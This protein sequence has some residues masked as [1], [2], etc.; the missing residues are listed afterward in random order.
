MIFKSAELRWF[1]REDSIPKSVFH[2]ALPHVVTQEEKMRTDLYLKTESNNTGIKIRQ[3]KH[4]LKL[5][6]EADLLYKDFSLQSWIKWSYKDTQSIIDMIRFPQLDD[7]IAIEK[8]RWI[9]KI[10]VTDQN[11]IIPIQDERVKRGCTLEYTEIKIKNQKKMFSFGL[12]AFSEDKNEMEILKFII[13]SLENNLLSLK[14][15][16]TSSYPGFLNELNIEKG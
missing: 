10:H 15:F 9:K 13:D 4:E 6:S 7:W 1:F 2:N 8:S 3:G 12:E 5:K 14:R 11:D 16:P